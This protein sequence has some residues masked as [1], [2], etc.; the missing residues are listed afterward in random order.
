MSKLKRQTSVLVTVSGPTSQ[1]VRLEGGQNECNKMHPSPC[2]FKAVKSGSMII[3]HHYSLHIF[4]HIQSHIITHHTLLFQIVPRSLGH[5]PLS[6]TFR[7]SPLLEMLH[8]CKSR[9]TYVS[10]LFIS[11]IRPMN[12]K[13]AFL[14]VL[15]L[16]FCRGVGP[17]LQAGVRPFP[18]VNK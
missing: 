6:R 5:L 14:M 15:H 17:V 9:D 7:L 4:T 11:K 13:M 3:A 1:E 18:I 10:F 12:G 2:N 8:V 16:T